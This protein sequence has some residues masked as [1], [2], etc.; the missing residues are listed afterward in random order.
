[1]PR[2]ASFTPTAQ[3][4]VILAEL[5]RATR[6]GHP[7]ADWHEVEPL[8]REVWESAS[9]GASWEQVRPQAATHWRSGDQY[10]C[11]AV[12][13]SPSTQ[14]AADIAAWTV[15]DDHRAQH[16]ATGYVPASPLPRAADEETY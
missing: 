14:Q 5:A 8:M 1:M 9:R 13:L 3:H 16:S 11:P 2:A 15:G 6:A 7:D 12:V 10:P 4:Q